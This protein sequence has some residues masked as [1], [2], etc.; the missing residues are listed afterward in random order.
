MAR[1]KTATK[2]SVC[3]FCGERIT[4]I[5]KGKFREDIQEYEWYT[6][7]H[8]CKKQKEARVIAETHRKAMSRW[9]GRTK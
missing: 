3:F 7:N 9:G 2:T 5:G 8:T 4:L 1:T 6:S